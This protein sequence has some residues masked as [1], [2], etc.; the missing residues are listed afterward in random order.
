MEAGFLGIQTN[1]ELPDRIKIMTWVE[2][3]Q[4]ENNNY[5]S[6]IQYITKFNDI[7]AAK[8]H[9][10][11]SL[12]HQLLDANNDLYKA[13]ITETIAAIE[14]DDD[15]RQQKVWIDPSITAADLK[16][17]DRLTKQRQLKNKRINLL[18]QLIGFLALGLLVLNFLGSIS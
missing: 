14:S 12:R 11:N 2:L 1:P 15:L 18:I 7:L 5:G 3:P 13:S 8:M 10:H 17:I 6:G 16:S 9:V 4:L